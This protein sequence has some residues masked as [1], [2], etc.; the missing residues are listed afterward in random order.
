MP[1]LPLKLVC[2]TSVLIKAIFTVIYFLIKVVHVPMISFQIV[3]RLYDFLN[4]EAEDTTEE[5]S[6]GEPLA[7]KT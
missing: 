4:E 7:V 2:L 1:S 5:A 6:D 3:D